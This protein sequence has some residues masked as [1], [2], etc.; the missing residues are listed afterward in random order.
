MTITAGDKHAHD[1]LLVTEDLNKVRRIC[2]PRSGTVR[3]RFF[4]RLSA[5]ST[6]TLTGA[7]STASSE[8]AL[9]SQ[10]TNLAPMFYNVASIILMHC[11]RT[12]MTMTLSNPISS[13]H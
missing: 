10:Y 7:L 1:V 8:N 2:Q 12:M 5:S 9:P 3:P 13:A 11:A 4:R 6:L